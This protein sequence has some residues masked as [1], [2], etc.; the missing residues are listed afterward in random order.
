MEEGGPGPA[1]TAGPGPEGDGPASG[2]GGAAAQHAG[3]S[4]VFT[5]VSLTN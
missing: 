2:S 5:S 4:G 3:N 1:H